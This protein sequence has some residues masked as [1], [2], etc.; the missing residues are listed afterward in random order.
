M[1]EKDRMNYPEMEKMS[2]EFKNAQKQIG[3]SMRQM[4]KVAKMSEDGALNGLGG[5][6]FQEAITQKLIPR[7]KVLEEKMGELSRDM[8]EA[9]AASKGAISKARSRFSN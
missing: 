2:K 4:K 7:M 1:P 9:V 6:A 5:N 3:D 8:N